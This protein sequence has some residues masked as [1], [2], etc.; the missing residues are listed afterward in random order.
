MF[1]IGMTLQLEQAGIEGTYKCRVCGLEEHAVLVDYPIHQKT[2]KSIFL[3]NGT[4][5]KVSFVL[6]DQTVLECRTG[7]VG[8]R[9]AEIPLIELERP[10]EEEF[11]RIQRRHFVRIEAPVDISLRAGEHRIVTVTEDISAGGCAVILREDSGIREEEEVDLF[12]V[13]PLQKAHHYLEMKG[14]VNRIWEKNRRVLASIE[15]VAPDESHKRHIMRFCFE[16]QLDH[17]KK[18]FA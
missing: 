8:R 13:L 3:M 7:V 16:K 5:L 10:S 9:M 12:L 17:R 14:R 4:P 1:E 15:F 18:G 11:K 6:K 2:G